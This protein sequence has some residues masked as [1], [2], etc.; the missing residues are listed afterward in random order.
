MSTDTRH[1]TIDVSVHGDQISGQVGDGTDQPT[2]FLG[3][4]G[5]I[6]ALD[7]L[8]RIRAQRLRS[9]TLPTSRD[10]EVAARM[11]GPAARAAST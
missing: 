5:L 3:W 7:R 10:D 6:G 9:R 4:L 11:S 2:P 8:L 1:I